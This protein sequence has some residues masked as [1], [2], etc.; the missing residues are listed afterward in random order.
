MADA[1]V[2]FSENQE[3]IAY[4]SNALNNASIN[5][6]LKVGFELIREVYKFC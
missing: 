2:H 5:T 1:Y 3:H 4:W 6:A